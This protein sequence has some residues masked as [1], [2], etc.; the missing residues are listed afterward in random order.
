MSSEQNITIELINVLFHIKNSYWKN[1]SEIVDSLG[2]IKKEFLI[3]HNEDQYIK[4]F[5]ELLKDKIIRKLPRLDKVKIKIEA[6]DNNNVL[7][8]SYISVAEMIVD[9]LQKR[10]INHN[11]S[12]FVTVYYENMIVFVGNVNFEGFK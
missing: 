11:K 1:T 5:I 2:E 6:L 12:I 4:K 8:R 7:H 10:K 3:C 9:K